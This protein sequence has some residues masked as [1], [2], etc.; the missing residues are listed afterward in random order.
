MSAG[1][2]HVEVAGLRIAYVRA[3]SGEPVVLLHGGFG[4]DHRSWLPQIE[5]LS[6]EF[7]V[8]AWDAPGTGESSDPPDAARVDEYADYLAGFLDAIGIERPHVVGLSYG[9]VLALALVRRHPAVPRS[10]VLA[11]A[12]A[13]WAGSLPPEQVEERLDRFAAEVE[14]PAMEWLPAYVPGMVS[15]HAS[16]ATTD[17]LLS[18]M[19]DIRPGPALVMLRGVAEADLRDVL[20]RIDVPTLLIYGELDAR[21]PVT[22]GEELHATIPGSELVVMPGVGHVCSFE[23]P[24]RFN[25]EVR[26]F[27]RSIG[28]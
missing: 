7:T 27:L 25:T 14:R 24:D 16:S 15:E 13:G 9:A 6:D 23:D 5:A 21:S 12:Y 17:A 22:V 28:G 11:G 3:G 20:P 8:V 26:N 1:V 19:V 18:L 2:E 4:A 10:L